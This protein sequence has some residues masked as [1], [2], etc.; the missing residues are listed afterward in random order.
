MKAMCMIHRTV[1]RPLLFSVALALAACGG[2]GSSGGSVPPGPTPTPVPG[3]STQSFTASSSNP[4]T[5]NF[6]ALSNGTAATVIV[7]I[8]NSSGT[9]T[10]TLSAT[11]PSG[12]P[13]VSSSARVTQSIGGAITPLAYVTVSANSALAF[14]QTPAVTL[15]T[16][17]TSSTYAYI[18]LFANNTW[19]AVAGPGTLVGGKYI[20]NPTDDNYTIAAGSLVVFAV[21][22]SASL[23]D[24][25]PPNSPVADQCPPSYK[26]AVNGHRLAQQGF[27]QVVSNRLYV[28]Y[29]GGTNAQTIARAVG[30]IRN[31]NLTP[32]KG[33]SHTVVTLAPGTNHDQAAATL[34]AQSGVV[35]VANIHTRSPLA[36][37]A[38]NDPGLNNDNQWYLYRTNADPAAWNLTHGAGITVAVIDT[39]VDMTNQDLAPKLTKA[40]SIVGGMITSSAQDTNGHGTNVAGLVAASTNNGYGFASIGWSVNLLDYKIFP[41]ANAFSDCQGADTADEAMAINDAVSSGASVIS[42]SLGA[43][44]TPGN[45]DPA[46]QDAV[47]AA[48]TAGVTVVAAAG[49][50]FDNSG[51]NGIQPDFPAAYAGVIAVGASAVFDSSMNNYNAITSEVV[52]SYSNSGPTLVAPGGDAGADPAADCSTSTSPCD[53]LHWIEGFSTT[54]AGLPADRCTNSGGVCA[55]LFNGTS[56]A[57]PQVAATAALMMAKHGGPRSLTPAQVKTILTN[58]ANIDLLPGISSTRQG[59]GRLNVGK[60]VAAS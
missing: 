11:P 51:V 21:F 5:V 6:A 45:S 54:S 23:I 32:T 37:A 43:P 2:G 36:D 31:I 26:R 19:T 17:S 30:A 47:E 20:I 27:S 41:D 25:N 4:T 39:G 33:V 8:A 16:T 59:A 55:V 22:G 49:N 24:V 29:N 14:G 28:S 7:P 58:P 9:G 60:A 18:A 13:A 46:E 42:M 35:S 57:T 50:E 44:N 3:G 1:G 15:T 40:E 52:A 12:V 10:A 56:Q 34:R 53:V 38:A 48:I